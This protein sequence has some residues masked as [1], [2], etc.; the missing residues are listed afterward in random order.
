M[1]KNQVFIQKA[2]N[3]ITAKYRS[4]LKENMIVSIGISRMY[5]TAEGKMVAKIYP[6]ELKRIIGKENDRN[7]YTQLKEIAKL[8]VGHTMVIENGRNFKVFNL[9]SDATYEDGVFTLIFNDTAKPLLC[10]LRTNYTTL[11]LL[12]LV[13]F[14]SNATYKLYEIFSKERYKIR[15]DGPREGNEPYVL[16]RY[17]ISELKFMISLANVEEDR[18]QKEIAKAKK[19]SDIDW[20]RLYDMALEKSYEKWSNFRDKVLKVAQ[21]EMK[22]KTEIRF[23]YKG[24]TKGR[25]GYREVEFKIFRNIPERAIKDYEEKERILKEGH[26]Y[27]LFEYAHREL[28]EKYAGHNGLTVEDLQLLIETAHEDEELVEKS[29]RMADL[30]GYVA[31]YMGWIISCIKRNYKD[32]TEVFEGSAERARVL[33][34][35]EEQI[36]RE[37]YERRT[38]EAVNVDFEETGYDEESKEQASASAGEMSPSALLW[39][40]IKRYEDFPEFL[41]ELHMDRAEQMEL[42]W[43][44]ERCVDIY[45]ECMEKRKKDHGES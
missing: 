29:I 42:I 36:L 19:T 23:E 4:T 25:L 26:Q 39:E 20:D 16:V 33:R 7:I 12:T 2:N 38:S 21:K 13:T 11:N 15:E 24:I 44:P 41:A 5:E 8:I 3:L 22:E 40:R 18:I 1:E 14:K 28:L 6:R 30:Q 34:E 27:S 10:N 17:N 37:D 31:N 32:P 9:V 35:Y 45:F 43:T